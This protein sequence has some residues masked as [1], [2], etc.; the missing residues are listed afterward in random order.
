MVL[1]DL[2]FEKR[3]YALKDMKD[4]LFSTYV[5]YFGDFN[6]ENTLCKSISVD[7]T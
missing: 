2:L 3:F 1:V 7:I 4:K 5:R 6:Q